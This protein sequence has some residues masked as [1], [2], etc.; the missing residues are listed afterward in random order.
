MGPAT[1][2]AVRRFQRSAGLVADGYPTLDL[3][4]RLQQP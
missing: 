1:R 2:E 4:A 3:L